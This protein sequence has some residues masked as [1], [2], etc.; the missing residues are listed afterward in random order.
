MGKPL[1]AYIQPM[2]KVRP[3]HNQLPRQNRVMGML[4]IIAGFAGGLIAGTLAGLLIIY[5]LIALGADVPLQ[6]SLSDPELGDLVSFYILQLCSALGGFLLPGLVLPRYIHGIRSLEFLRLKTG[7][8]PQTLLWA[9][10]LYASLNPLMEW[11]QQINNQFHLPEGMQQVEDAL[12]SKTADYARIINALMG[13]GGY[14]RLLINLMVVA[15]AAALAEEVFFRG[16]LQRTLYIYTARLHA[17]V[18]LTA[19]LFSAVHLDIYGFLPRMA[20]GMVLG[21][22]YAFSG[23]LWLPITLHFLNN[24]S[25]VAGVFL[26]KKN[27]WDFSLDAPT[28]Y[29]IG[30]VIAG[31]ALAF[32]LALAF[33]R[34]VRPQKT[35]SQPAVRDTRGWISVH[36]AKDSID[37]S[38]IA[39]LLM[40][41]GIEAVVMD[42]R[43]PL[44]GFGDVEIWVAETD[45]ERA[46]AIINSPA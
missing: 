9:V 31:T 45:S 29:P 36:S 46:A 10:L 37:A 40:D 12:K 25:A 6:P 1:P 16:L 17:S 23:S 42:K 38:L 22:V 30:V 33:R 39:A 11:L 7:F 20:I 8:R 35:E 27:G 18:I 4:A 28:Q 15:G 24:A 2:Q 3:L 19:I 43:V 32:M 34:S 41:K 14:G 21:Y 26:A 13:G 44:Y 5:A